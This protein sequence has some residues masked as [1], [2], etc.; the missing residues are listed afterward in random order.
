MIRS[1]IIQWETWN[2]DQYIAASSRACM[3]VS[4]ISMAYPALYAI[5]I[6]Y[7]A[8]AVGDYAFGLMFHTALF[9]PA[10][11]VSL[12]RVCLSPTCIYE[13]VI[14]RVSMWLAEKKTED[15]HQSFSI[16]HGHVHTSVCELLHFLAM[17]VL[18]Y[19]LLTYPEWC[20]AESNDPMMNVTDS[21]MK[22]CLLFWLMQNW[23]SQQVFSNRK[24]S[25]RSENL[26]NRL[27]QH[28]CIAHKVTLVR[29]LLPLR[30]FPAHP[31]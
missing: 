30:F 23:Q 28:P 11:H 25:I 1:V 2:P 26:L 27:I 8:D 13:H 5:K 21:Q 4:G 9:N 16:L 29:G 6:R 31:F 19:S 3:Y 18:H 12:M 10:F 17:H 20:P 15:I 24:S 7:G 22:T 14:Q